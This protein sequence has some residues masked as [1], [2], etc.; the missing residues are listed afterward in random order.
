MVDIVRPGDTLARY[1]IERLL[2]RKTTEVYTALSCST[3]ARV[4]I[5]CLDLQRRGH[6]AP[7][8]ATF[9]RE[10]GKLL[11]IRD[12]RFP[13]VLDGGVQGNIR[14]I[15]EEQIEAPPQ[16]LRS[17]ELPLYT[18]A[19]STVFTMAEALG[20]ARSRHDVAH[21]DL[22]LES[23]LEGADVVVLGLGCAALF[24]VAR[25][26]ITSAP[27]YRAPEQLDGAVVLDARADIYSA[28]MILYALLAG[29]PPF[30]T[31]SRAMPSAEDALIMAERGGALL[32]P[33]PLVRGRGAEDAWQLIQKATARDPRER[34]ASW[35]AFITDVMDLT[36]L[37]LDR[38]AR[39]QRFADETILKEQAAA[40]FIDPAEAEDVSER[41]AER[42]RATEV[43]PASDV[44]AARAVIT[45]EAEASPEVEGVS[46][47]VSLGAHGEPDELEGDT[48]RAPPPEG[49]EN[50]GG[51][52]TTE[53]S[54]TAHIQPV[55][56]PSAGP[57]DAG[58]DELERTGGPRLPVQDAPKA[59]PPRIPRPHERPWLG[60]RLGDALAAVTVLVS[61]ALL[62]VVSRWTRGDR[63]S[64]DR[65]ECVETAST[66]SPLRSDPEP[67]LPAPALALTAPKE[68]P[69]RDPPKQ[70]A[71]RAGSPASREES[72][73]FI[74]L[75][76]RED[77][78]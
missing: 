26:A 28:G 68:A 73:F 40:A 41:R 43:A 33:L 34:Y 69:T 22:R 51:G 67:K 1:R 4:I 24:G 76:E 42:P 75:N 5:R 12:P 66:P 65:S 3:G 77:E 52:G 31:L 17:V 21:G 11:A 23:I 72:S 62:V 8:D 70:P 45:A 15:A 9:Y 7:G 48:L 36:R 39:E 16:R 60:R 30:A 18:E 61:A 74:H 27:L 53:S 55:I 71:L 47:I 38:D 13:A 59:Q 63:N 50:T 57:A 64:A 10:L 54:D 29:R 49:M 2:A 32:T 78:N 14:W 6:T 25:K 37:M 56:R 35:E 44:R 20:K 58:T 46:R 19:L